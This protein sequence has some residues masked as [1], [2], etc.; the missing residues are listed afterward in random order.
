MLTRENLQGLVA[1]VIWISSALKEIAKQR[2]IKNA[3]L[4]N[5]KP[6]KKT[7]CRSSTIKCTNRKAQDLNRKIV[8]Q[9]DVI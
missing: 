9:N 8:I 3:L 1:R 7:T 6:K 2:N 4:K 5:A